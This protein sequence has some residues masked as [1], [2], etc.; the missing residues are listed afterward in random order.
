MEVVNLALSI[1]LATF[2]SED[3]AGLGAGMLVAHSRLGYA[4]AVGSYFAG[5]LAS[6]FLLFLLGRWMGRSAVGRA[7]ANRLVTEDTVARSARWIEHQG[8]HIVMVSRFLPGTRLPTYV[9]AGFVGVSPWRF[10]GYFAVAAAIWSPLIVSAGALPTAGLDR[11]V[12]AR[13]L[14]IASLEH[15]GAAGAG[16]LATI[17]LLVAIAA[18]IR[19]T[20]SLINYRTRRAWIGRWKRITRWEFW[21]MWC[22]YPPVV[23]Y[24]VWL[25][26]K[27]RCLTAFTACN[28]GIVGGG[29]VGESK[30]DIL[31]RIANVDTNAVPPFSVVP[32]YAASSVATHIADTHVAQHGYP[33]V[34]KPDQGQRGEGVVIA[35]SHAALASAVRVRQTDLILQR[36]VEGSEFGVFYYRRPAEPSGC[37]FAITEK[38]MPVVEGD[39][40]RSLERLILDH[41]RAVAMARHYCRANAHRLDWIPMTSERVQLSE[42]GVHSRGALFLDGKTLLTPAL[43]TA[44]DEL[45]RRIDGFYFGRFDVRSASVDEFRAGRF[46]VIE[47]NGVTSE[48]TSIYDPH[49]GLSAAYRVLCAQW[50]LAFE[51]GAANIAS[52]IP[53]TPVRTLAALVLAYRRRLRSQRDTDTC[54]AP[55]RRSDLSLS[56]VDGH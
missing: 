2:V 27:H 3:L 31:Q 21:P 30:A 51:I 44:I 32:R 38:Q 14:P 11:L 5:V 17:A 55:A 35:R 56:T 19:L 39:G 25:G 50:R 41:P 24:V 10:L 43:S 4:A 37:V 45:A 47:L 16:A 46:Q 33:V 26:L 22:V 8:A 48:A 23:A 1:A 49:N 40:E 54:A 6:D 28:P 20:T 34:V 52:G 18:A 53:A 29:F 13:A 9:A 36:Y 42:L 7:I 12:A 15:L